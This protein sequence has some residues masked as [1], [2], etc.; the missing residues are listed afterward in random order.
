MFDGAGQ[1]GGQL[2]CG[3]G[4][5]AAALVLDRAPE[6]GRAAGA[7]ERDSAVRGGTGPAAWDPGRAPAGTALVRAL[8]GWS[9]FPLEGSCGFLFP[10]ASSGYAR[11]RSGD[12]APAAAA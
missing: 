6:A 5:G 12:R 7:W 9:C 2:S 10:D 4:P 3:W 11:R 8:A 1:S